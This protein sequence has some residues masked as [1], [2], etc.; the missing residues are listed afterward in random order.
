MK[1]PRHLLTLKDWS[2]KEILDTISLASKIK[3]K[4]KE[5]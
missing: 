1:K 2:K 5:V 3:K 4:S